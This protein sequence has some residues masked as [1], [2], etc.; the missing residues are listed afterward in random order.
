MIL[1]LA[2]ALVSS[3]RRFRRTSSFVGVFYTEFQLRDW[4]SCG[5]SS[6][7]LLS[8]WLVLSSTWGGSLLL[9]LCDSWGDG[10]GG[11]RL[12]FVLG[13]SFN[14]FSWSGCDPHG[15]AS[16]LVFILAGFHALGGVEYLLN[17]SLVGN[18][19]FYSCAG[20]ERERDLWPAASLLLSSSCRQCR[21]SGSNFVIVMV[22]LFVLA[23]GLL[24]LLP[25]PPKK[26]WASH[27]H[28]C[29]IIDVH[30]RRCWSNFAQVFLLHLPERQQQASN[31]RV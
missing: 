15:V 28:T 10:R 18:E 27:D 29:G 6:R 11:L 14:D 8:C 19:K 30:L 2:A 21:C 31:G 5:L 23:S 9:R 17:F 7:A 24:L 4:T 26:C 20:V 3:S 16:T 1:L 12:E 22:P 25:Q 13:I